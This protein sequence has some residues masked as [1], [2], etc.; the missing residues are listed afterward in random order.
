MITA[1]KFEEAM[2][3]PP[4]NDDLE[5]CN[6]PTQGEP[7]HRTCGWCNITNLPRYQCISCVLKEFNPDALGPEHHK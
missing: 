4:E 2:G 6:C 3:Q 5:R 7:G 1:E